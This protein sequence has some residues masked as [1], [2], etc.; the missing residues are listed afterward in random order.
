MTV[1]IFVAFAGRIAVR[2][3]PSPARSLPFHGTIATNIQMYQDI[4]REEIEEAARFVDAAP[5]IEK[6]PEK[7]DHL[8]T[9]RGTSFRQVN[10]NFWPL[11]APWPVSLR[12]LF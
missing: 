6:L 4:S 7:Y 5:F 8:V 12:F 3:W 1:R 9:E 10:G 2:D 11:H